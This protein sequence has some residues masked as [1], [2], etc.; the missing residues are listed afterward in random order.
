[1]TLVATRLVRLFLDY[2]SP[3]CQVMAFHFPFNSWCSREIPRVVGVMSSCLEEN[4]C[5]HMVQHTYRVKVLRVHQ[6]MT[7]RRVLLVSVLG[8]TSL[9]GFEQSPKGKK[10]P[11]EIHIFLFSRSDVW[12]YVSS[13]WILSLKD[14][15]G[16][17]GYP[18]VPKYCRDQMSPADSTVATF[19]SCCVLQ[20]P[21]EKISEAEK[22]SLAAD[23]EGVWRHKVSSTEKK[24]VVSESRRDMKCGKKS[25]YA[26]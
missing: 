17:P 4:G 19:P 12:R 8:G 6:E 3:S 16:V 21:Q 24:K 9:N 1:M 13:P 15:L 22:G 18:Q 23:R 14:I 25:N 26:S 7:T 10:I 11:V 2:C 20:N 5:F